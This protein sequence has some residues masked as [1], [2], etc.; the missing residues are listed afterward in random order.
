MFEGVIYW[1]DIEKNP[2]DLPCDD[3]LYLTSVEYEKDFLLGM[4]SGYKYVASDIVYD[5]SRNVW[6]SDEGENIFAVGLSK[7]EVER[8][9]KIESNYESRDLNYNFE[10][11][12]SHVV[13]WTYYPK[14]YERE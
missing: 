8:A 7:T 1:H 11:S 12:A 3:K 9:N 5:K 10:Y 6:Y 4:N 14:P 13:A 2:A